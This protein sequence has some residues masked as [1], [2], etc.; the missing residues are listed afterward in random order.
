MGCLVTHDDPHHAA[1]Q[2]AERQLSM[3][4]LELLPYVWWRHESGVQL[5]ALVTRVYAP[6]LVNLYVL[7]DGYLDLGAGAGVAIAK[8]NVREGTG[9]LMWQL[10][11][12]P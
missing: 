3:R 5:K 7:S 9:H 2:L 4:Q 8:T 6:Q 11:L 1:E 10:E 12:D